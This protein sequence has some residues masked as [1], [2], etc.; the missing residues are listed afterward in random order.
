MSIPALSIRNPVMTTMLCILIVAAGIMSYLKIPLQDQPNITFPA[1]TITTLLPGGNANIINESVTKP[2]EKQMNTLARIQTL[3]SSSESGKSTVTINFQLGTNMNAS[4]NQIANKLNHIRDTL[5]KDIQPPLIDVASNQGAPIIMYSLYGS[6]DLAQMNEFAREQIVTKLQNIE[7][8]GKVM[9]TGASEQ[10]VSIELDLHKLA[11][12]RIPPMKVQQAFNQANISVPGGL[13]RAGKKQY[14]LNLDLSYHKVEELNNIIVGYR[15]NAPIFLKDIATVK[16]GFETEGGNAF[17][18]SKPSIGI[19]VVRQLDAN[20]VGVISAVQQRINKEVIPNLPEGVHL[21]VVYSQSNFIMKIIHSLERDIW[22]AVLSAGLVIFL[23]L[24]SIRPTF[25]IVAVVP[26]SLLGAIAVIQMFGFTLNAITLLSLTVLVGIVV[27][28]SVI[29]LENISREEKFDTTLTHQQATIVGAD[30]VALPVTACSLSL[31]SIFLPIVFMG[32]IMSVLFKP[33]AIVITAGILFSLVMSLTFNPVLCAKFLKKGAKENKL[34]KFLL[35]GFDALNRAY[36]P[37]LKLFLNHRWIAV[38]VVVA[39]FALCVPAFHYVNKTFMPANKNTGYFTVA[40]QAPEGMSTAYTRERV[41][42]AEKIIQQFPGEIAHIFSSTGPTANQGSI[43]VQLKPIEQLKVS[44]AAFMARLT[45]EFQQIPGALFFVELPN[46]ATQITYQIQGADFNKVINLSYKFLAQVQKTPELGQSYI[47]MATNQPQFQVFIDRVLANSFGITAYDVANTL[48]TM[49]SSGQRI[50]HFTKGAN[51]KRYWVLLRPGKDQFTSTDDLS[52]IYVTSKHGKPVRLDTIVDLEQSLMPSKITR[53]DMNY[54]IGFSSEPTI[55]TNKSIL[56]VQDIAKKVLP[57]GYVLKL[58]GNT[59]SLGS[60]EHDL[61]VTLLL[62]L[63]LIYI[64]LASQFNSFL[65]PLI[66][67]L[68]QP[69]AIVAGLFIL[70]LTNETLNVYS[71]IGILLL[72]GLSTKNTIMLVSL[73]NNAVR[74]GKSVWDAMFQISQDRMRPILMTALALVMAE[75]PS[76]F[77]SGNTYRSLSMVILAGVALS[78]LLSL[79]VIPAFYSMFAQIAPPRAKV[80]ISIPAK[81]KH[82]DNETKGD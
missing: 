1:L 44:Q 4:Y 73:G 78:G 55:S 7:G 42:A 47:Y 63:G 14:T 52:N 26:I 48:S 39:M 66:V 29:V 2:I 37:A 32:G 12:M 61:I 67:I 35:K 46:N 45:K 9:V 50:G 27:D 60:T 16:F 30:E 81:Y 41:Q 13:V 51:G 19:N 56:L 31:V 28:D 17:F 20:T 62:I 76:I 34:G 23:F 18:N 59:A 15:H 22:L 40:V 10:A 80:N 53:T 8:V 65:Q 36:V 33:F 70:V 71:M 5:P 79:F 54:S 75:L 3:S 74:S 6:E 69:L 38:V 77:D 21:K 11:A 72:V 25:I 43:S 82:S 68:M 58:T 24:R 49:S 57:K 64:V